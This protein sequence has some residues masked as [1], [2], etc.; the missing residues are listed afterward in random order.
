MS[1]SAASLPGKV[2]LVTG[3]ATLLFLTR[4]R[5]SPFR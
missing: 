2:A 5:P 4:M 3:A 1:N